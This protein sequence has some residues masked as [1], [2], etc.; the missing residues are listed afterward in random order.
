MAACSLAVAAPGEGINLTTLKF[1]PSLEVKGLHNSNVDYVS[2][3]EKAD[4]SI[5]G[6]LILPFENVTD[7]FKAGGSAWGRSQRYSSEGRLDHDDYG[8]SLRLAVGTMDTL[9]VSG[10]GAYQRMQEFDYSVGRIEERYVAQAGAGL[11]RNVTDK[12]T[13][14]AAYAYDSTDYRS[15]GLYDWNQNAGSV[16]L[17]QKL[18]DKSAATLMG[19]AGMISSDANQK[20]ADFMI[21][22][23]GMKAVATT[24]LQGK[25]GVGYQ[26]YDVYRTI[27]GLSYM[28]GVAW[29]A[30]ARL[31]LQFQANNGI[32]PATL[33][34]NENNYINTTVVR[35]NTTV[36]VID[37][38]AA[39]I[40]GQYRRQ[41]YDQP[42]VANGVATDKDEDSYTGTL[43]LTYQPPAKFVEVFVE[44]GYEQRQ[45]TLANN[46]YDQTLAALGMTLKY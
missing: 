3:N 35:A 22:Q 31:L 7:M 44:G 42:V 19:K 34:G 40:L 5:M 18:T 27:D 2:A 14:D 13:I 43:R 20:D 38:V 25:V 4:T 28:A 30:T 24:K 41:E 29:Q 8:A 46:E 45:S 23:A 26:S 39:S 6:T 12:M 16:E 17:A 9:V 15:A 37:T 1:T 36:Q 21:V 32:E 11:G 10:N 33:R